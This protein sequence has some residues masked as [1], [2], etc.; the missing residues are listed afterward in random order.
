[1]TGSVNPRR[2]YD[3]SRRQE[4]AARTRARILAAARELLLERGYAST[5]VATVADGAD[6]SVETVYKAFGNKPGLLKALFDVAVVGDDDPVPLLEREFVQRNMAE[7]DPRRKLEQYGAHLATTVPRTAP[8]QLLARA[9]A[10]T[11]PAAAEVWE[12][13]QAERLTGMT[14]FATHLHGAG[15]LRAEVTLE[16]ARDV[17]WAHNSVELYD[18]LVLHRGW[19]PA[20]Y[21]AWVGRALVAALLP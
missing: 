15:H 10:L 17:L 6:V 9:A 12:Q 5:T 19:S 1:M 8:V 20:R 7:P 14:A 2:T 4:Q 18:L 3:A 21:G 11:D 16:E 13:M